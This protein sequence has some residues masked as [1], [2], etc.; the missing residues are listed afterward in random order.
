MDSGSGNANVARA[1]GKNAR[2]H[3][4][5]TGLEPDALFP[6]AIPPVH[7]ADPAVRVGGAGVPVTPVGQE[8]VSPPPPREVDGHRD[9]RMVLEPVPQVV[10][11]GRHAA[12]S[13]PG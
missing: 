6:E 11:A 1:I 3:S 8:G 10:C 2:D 5:G 12:E 9:V 4:Y 7:Q 13:L